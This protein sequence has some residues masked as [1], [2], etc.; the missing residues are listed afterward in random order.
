MERGSVAAGVLTVLRASKRVGSFTS[1]IAHLILVPPI[2]TAAAILLCVF[3]CSDFY[4]STIHLIYG[5]NGQFCRIIT[6]TSHDQQAGQGHRI[7]RS[8]P[9]NSFR[10]SRVLG[11]L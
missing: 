8:N 3:I 7:T 4:W 11:V 5:V 6:V 9:H 2:S 1:A 10:P